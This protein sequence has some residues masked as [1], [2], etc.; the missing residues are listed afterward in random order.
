[1]NRL[2]KSSLPEWL[3]GL[4]AFVLAVL[5]LYVI[6][7]SIETVRQSF[8]NN[9]IFSTRQ[10]ESFFAWPLSNTVMGLLN[11]IGVSLLSVAASG[12][13]GVFL[14]YTFW[15][16]EFWGKSWLSKLF[17]LP[18][19]LP[20]L[21]GV[22]AFS[23][24]YSDVGV[25]P[26]LVEEVFGK[27]LL[28]LEGIGAVVAVHLYSFY[29]HFFLFGYA[30]LSNLDVA[31]L[32]AAENLGASRWQTFRRI[33]L[34]LLMPSLYGA[35]LIV[36]I[37][38]MASFTAPLLFATKTR[39]LTVQIFTAKESGNLNL[40][41]AMS[42]VLVLVSVALLVAF[43]SW[44]ARSLSAGGLSA[45]GASRQSAAK[46][47]PVVK[48]IFLAFVWLM[49]LFV[50][51]PVMIMGVFA[52]MQNGS[53]TTQLFP[54][55]Y[56]LQNFFDIFRDSQFF[57]PFVT[58]LGLALVASVMNL[59]FGVAAGVLLTQKKIGL[60][61]FISVSL[62]L[63]LAIPG[64]VIAINLISAFNHPS[65]LAFGATLVGSVIILPLAYFIRNIPYITRAVAAALS[66]MD[67]S[68]AEAAE[69]LGASKGRVLIRVTLPVIAA[70]VASGFLIS[71][72]TAAG[73]F[74]SSIMLYTASTKPVSV[75][76]FSQFR[77]FNLG[78]AAAESVILMLIIFGLSSL[79]NRIFKNKNS[80]SGLD[81]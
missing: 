61:T 13:V 60:R 47:K 69:N 36:F 12:I 79:S 1:M 3:I 52:F 11:T 78:T 54:S 20:P 41:Y 31:L 68:L 67:G 44:N 27:R 58:S 2:Q 80:L 48:F 45:K 49:L 21:V 5:V 76:I 72:I 51:L 24:L 53:W 77:N 64:T 71:F 40:A 46:D 8:L 9:G 56:T 43:E 55:A 75:E 38:S 29:V 59:A 23:F 35:S 4:N 16:F 62:L 26:R 73:E 30:A 32:E 42:V 74:V 66:T 65:V 17:L 33:I 57:T 70:A 18:L 37:L 63:P 7:P 81:V 22:F 39:F 6:Y 14:A 10:Y 25:L 19:G 50:M 15:R 28:V 34:P